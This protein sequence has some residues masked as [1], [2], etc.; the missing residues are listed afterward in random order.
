MRGSYDGPV[1]AGAP[2]TNFDAM[3]VTPSKQTTE[4]TSFQR[5][6]YCTKSVT[7][8]P[9]ILLRKERST[10]AAADHVG[11]RLGH[12]FRVHRVLQR[13]GIEELSLDRD[14]PH[15]LASLETLLR[16]VRGLVVADQR[17][18]ARAHRQRLLAQRS[19]A[20]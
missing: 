6:K 17:R 7:R 18:E 16:D 20:L 13:R 4:L 10:A 8:A 1:G 2:A 12:P 19:A 14:L 11:L 5:R 15:G 9:S 3:I